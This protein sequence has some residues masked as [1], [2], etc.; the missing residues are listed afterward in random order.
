MFYPLGN[1]MFHEVKID[2]RIICILPVYNETLELLLSGVNSILESNYEKSLM[3]VHISFDDNIQS[4]LYKDLLRYFSQK[5]NI[6]NRTSISFQVNGT[7]IYVH[8]WLHGGK[9]ITQSRT[10][11]FI[12]NIHNNENTD[13]FFV[14]LTD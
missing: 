11:N 14:L 10:W 6:C 1:K 4:E 2:S 3:E 8:K 7:I 9:R 5:P 12:M 13:N